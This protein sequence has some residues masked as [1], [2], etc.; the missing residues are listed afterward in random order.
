MLINTIYIRELVKFYLL[1][2]YLGNY[3][4]RGPLKVNK[5]RNKGPKQSTFTS[6]KINNAG[7]VKLARYDANAFNR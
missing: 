6:R 4:N 5:K 3:K 1:C 7:A 2:A